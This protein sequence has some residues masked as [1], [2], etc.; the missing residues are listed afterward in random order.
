M[1]RADK[2]ALVTKAV[3]AICQGEFKDYSNAAKR[4]HCS[5][6]FQPVQTDFLRSTLKTRGTN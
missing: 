6:P 5:Y 4:F 3:L 2:L 1:E